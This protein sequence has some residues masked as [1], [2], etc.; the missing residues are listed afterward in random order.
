MNERQGLA[1]SD[2]CMQPNK[3][4]KPALPSFTHSLYCTNIAVEPGCPVSTRTPAS[5][6][7]VI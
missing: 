5:L 1:K 2:V 6:S 7:L 4:D 3:S